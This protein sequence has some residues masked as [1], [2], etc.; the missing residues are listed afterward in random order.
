[1][2]SNQ[3]ESMGTAPKDIDIL[4]FDYWSDINNQ[5]EYPLSYKYVRI[6]HVYWGEDFDNEGR[7]MPRTDCR[8]EHVYP[9]CWRDMIDLPDLNVFEPYTMERE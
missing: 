5:F 7:W 3:W 9:V 1:M 8:P 4:I 2:M 6:V